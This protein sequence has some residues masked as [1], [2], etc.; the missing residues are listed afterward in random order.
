MGGEGG[1][2]TVTTVTTQSS[3]PD[4]APHR[5]DATRIS[6]TTREK[7]A[8]PT[9][10]NPQAPATPARKSA[11]LF[12][13]PTPPRGP[14]P[15]HMSIVGWQRAERGGRRAREA[16]ATANHQVPSARGP[17]PRGPSRR[18]PSEGREPDKMRST[19]S[20]P[21]GQHSGR[22][23]GGEGSG[24][25]QR[26]RSVARAGAPRP[27]PPPL[28]LPPPPRWRGRARGG[29]SRTETSSNAPPLRCAPRVSPRE[30]PPR[31]HRDRIWR[32]FERTFARLWVAAAEETPFRGPGVRP[33][34][35]ASRYRKREQAPRGRLDE[36][37]LRP[38][39]VGDASLGAFVR[40]GELV[41]GLVGDTRKP[42]PTT[43]TWR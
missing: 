37:P 1:G 34:R 20:E 36:L 8:S 43:R 5:L 32:L 39:S 24:R 7:K 35:R 6:T 17:R 38:R 3:A 41:G 15:A 33:A 30:T 2:G 31:A 22:H 28:P 23:R 42:C 12:S 4:S 26:P 11:A 18:A 40:I 9:T 21:G 19:G 25:A 10:R 27:P 16:R 29:K 13:H 14:A